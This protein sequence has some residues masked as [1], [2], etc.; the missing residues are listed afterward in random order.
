MFL[1]LHMLIKN[2][3][4]IEK[5]TSCIIFCAS[6]HVN[7]FTLWCKKLSH[8]SY[9]I[10]FW[11]FLDF[12]LEKADDEKRIFDIWIHI[13]IRY[14]CLMISMKKHID[15]IREKSHSSL[16][17]EIGIT[18]CA[19]WENSIDLK[20]W[21]KLIYVHKKKV[22]RAIPSITIFAYVC[23]IGA[24]K[25]KIEGIPPSILNIWE[26]LYRSVR[27]QRR[28]KYPDIIPT[29]FEYRNDISIALGNFIRVSISTIHINGLIIHSCERTNVNTKHILL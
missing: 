17:D 24:S 26:S 1:N 23:R 15:F 20:I 2:L 19:L 16:C 4:K 14:A 11:I 8:Y 27:I 3:W 21:K 13:E 12:V 25:R 7:L 18:I 22:A 29:F 5:T 6:L 10:V 28:Q 9:P